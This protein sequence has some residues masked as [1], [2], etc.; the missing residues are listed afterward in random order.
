MTHFCQRRETFII[1]YYKLSY[2][3]ASR[4]GTTVCVQPVEPPPLLLNL[5]TWIN[6]P[7]EKSAKLLVFRD[8]SLSLL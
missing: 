6:K 1:I 3:D 7:F 8:D 2:Y 4:Y 5:R